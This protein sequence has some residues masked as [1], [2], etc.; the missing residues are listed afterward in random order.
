MAILAFLWGY[1]EATLFIFVPDVLISVVVIRSGW[2]AAVGTAVAAALGAALCG[3]TMHMWAT[4]SPAAAR[5]T[6]AALPAIDA[7][8]I[9]AAEQALAADG[10]WAMLRGS[11]GGTPYKIFAVAAGEQHLPVAQFLLLTP[12]IR[13]PRFLL[14]VL[15]TAATAQVLSRW[16]S[17]RSA[18]TLLAVFWTLFYAAYFAIMAA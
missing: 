9:A 15:V 4:H 3:L 1:A 18:M 13:L 12:L 14:T 8:R 11:F 5:A 10:Y 2:R 6:I 16:L 7:A 17:V